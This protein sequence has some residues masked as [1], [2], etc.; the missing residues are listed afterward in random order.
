VAVTNSGTT[1]AFDASLGTLTLTAA[2]GWLL[3]FPT[4]R[5][6]RD[7]GWKTGRWD[8]VP[9][10]DDYSVL[11]PKSLNGQLYFP[12]P[13]SPQSSVLTGNI[14]MTPYRQVYLSSSLT[15]FRTL[16][17]GTGTKDILARIPL[18]VNYGEVNT[19]RSYTH[20]A[21]GASD[22][23]FRTMRFRFTDWAGRL[24]PIDQPVI[25]ELVFLD[26]DPFAM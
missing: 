15:N 6:L 2:S 16:Q 17:S 4:E 14:G 5:E 1:A 23:H 24:V 12:S 20:D 19:F 9:N 7:Q 26:S 22:Q 13:S 18:E 8:P 25:I 11:D 21:L 10:A 3:Q